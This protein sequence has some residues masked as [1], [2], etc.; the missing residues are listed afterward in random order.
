[1]P[2]KGP[3]NFEECVKRLQGDYSDRITKS[4]T[5]SA[6]I[7][8]YLLYLDDKSFDCVTWDEVVE[9]AAKQRKEGNLI[10]RDSWDTL[11][12]GSDKR[13]RKAANSPQIDSYQ[14][15]G[16]ILTEADKERMKALCAYCAN[17]AASQAR[18]IRFRATLLKGQLLSQEQFQVAMNSPALA[19]YSG[20]ELQDK[21][22]PLLSPCLITKEDHLDDGT[23]RIEL[24]FSS[25]N[26]VTEAVKRIKTVR[27]LGFSGSDDLPGDDLPGDALP[28]VSGSA[29]DGMETLGNALSEDFQWHQLDAYVFLLCGLPPAALDMTMKY[30]KMMLSS[31]PWDNGMPPPPLHGILTLQLPYWLTDKQVAAVYRRYHVLAGH[32]ALHAGRPTDAKSIR[33][34]VFIS[35]QEDRFANTISMWTL[36][37][38]RKA[39]YCWKEECK[40]LGRDEGFYST[41]KRFIRRGMEVSKAYRAR[42]TGWSPESREGYYE[43]RKE[44]L[45]GVLEGNAPTSTK[46]A[47]DTSS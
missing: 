34:F 18:V 12:S 32:G 44:Y 15:F 14:I 11:Q 21:G 42:F 36:S 16:D 9:T 47:S 25:L 10:E 28:I 20:A 1:M 33:L 43:W 38:K 35:R 26:L 19:I 24:S 4:V 41:L 8:D 7:K 46:I 22:I 23:C 6:K 13:G 40:A 45:A 2:I 30:K 27:S 17:D 31:S 39:Y 5:T 29:I 3:I 37:Q